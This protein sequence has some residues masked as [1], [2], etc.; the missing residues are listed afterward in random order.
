MHSAF[1][2]GSWRTVRVGSDL[3]I[4]AVGSAVAEATE[5]SE[6]L[7]AQGCSAAVIDCNQLTGLSPDYLDQVLSSTQLAISI[8][9]HSIHGGLSSLVAEEIA[10]RG[11]GIR[12]L[13]FGI[14][15]HYSNLA[16]SP[17][18]LRGQHGISAAAV[19]EAVLT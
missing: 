2:V 9:E 6:R 14:D 11:L 8:E 18:Y 13:R 7:S 10:A 16:G 12:L 3:A 19:V 17:Q 5:A 15:G 1:E 4:F